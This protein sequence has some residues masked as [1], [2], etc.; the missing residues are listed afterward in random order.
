M[1]EENR[2][3]SAAGGYVIV[4]PI[5]AEDVEMVCLE[6]EEMLDSESIRT[7]FIGD[8]RVVAQLEELLS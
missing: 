7:M 4:G 3:Q 6:V 2:S 8:P 5:A 1:A